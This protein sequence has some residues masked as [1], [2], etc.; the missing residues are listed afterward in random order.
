MK[1]RAIIALALVATFLAS[2]NVQAHPATAKEMARASQLLIK[3]LPKEQKDK[4][5]FEWK[6]DERHNWHFIPRER[7]GLALKEMSDGA[8]ALAH[9][10]IIT[11][12]SHQGYKQ[13]LQVMN[14]EQVLYDL[15][16]NRAMR[17]PGKYYISIFGK[18]EPKGT[19]GWRLEGHHLSLNYTIVKGKAIAVTPAFYATNPAKVKEGPFKGLRVL[20]AE[21]D[22]ARKLAKSLTD[23][24]RKEAIVLDNKAPKDIITSAER[25]VSMLKPVGISY[26][27][28]TDEQKKS[29]TSLINRYLKKSRNTLAQAELKR[30]EEAGWDKVTFGWAG[31]LKPGEPHYYRVQGPHFLLEYDNVQNGANHVHAVWRDFENDFGGDILKKHY[32]ESHQ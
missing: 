7:K 19:W 4:M 14:L 27:K 23:E 13:T 8:R 29:L 2:S 18:P 11:G 32:E 22:L 12:L 30:I 21:E 16:D 24:Q 1:S 26:A 31:G 20:G 25:K 28:L 3:S 10:L 5:R 9:A 15:D 17:D 6:A